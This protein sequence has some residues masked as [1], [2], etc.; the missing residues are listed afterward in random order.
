MTR[1][2]VC[3][4]V[5][6][7]CTA[8][9]GVGVGMTAAHP[10]EPA[11]PEPTDQ[12]S[13]TVQPILSSTE[14]VGCV[15]GICHDDDLEFDE[16]TNLSEAELDALA[17]RTMARVEYLRDEPFTEEVP[18]EIQSRE[19][20]RQSDVAAPSRSDEDFER[21]NDQVWRG[22]FVVGDEQSSGEAIDG[23]VGEAVNGFY[24]P[25]E[26]QIVLVTPS[27]DIPTVD[28]QTLL[29]EFAHALQD[30][31]HNLTS[32]QF[33]GET[34]DRDLAV[35]GVLEGEA[36]YLEYRYEERC[37]S[38]EWSCFD[39]PGGSGGSSGELN[40][41]ILYTLLQPYSDGPA[42]VHEILETEGW[43]GIDERMETPPETTRE[44]IHRQPTEAREVES[45]PDPT[46]GWEP[47][48]DQGHNGTETVG[49]AS[50]FVMLWYQA[51]EY[52]A[53]TIDP[54]TLHETTHEY[55]QFNYVSEPSDG[56]AG[57]QLVPYQRGDDDGYV[58]TLEWETRDD[59]AEFRRAYDAILDA[60]DSTETDEGVYVLSS[61]PFSGAYAVETDDTRVR[62]VHAPT[63]AGL[64]ELDPSLEPTAFEQ[65]P[66]DDTAPGFSVAAAIAAL[67]VLAIAARRQYQ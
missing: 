54:E 17:A 10:S 29:H 55:E 3:V 33:R 62:I 53:D 63:E 7:L 24:L 58:W 6:L 49:E 40:R 27:P 14:E 2:L 46:E 32:P 26:G 57:D 22:L 38:G 25:G 42:Y 13:T 51:T 21:W 41:G 34:Q 4:L 43:E 1:R 36:V 64:F 60:H 61:G 66:L 44:I 18:V 39:D 9:V 16:P 28:E 67:L 11:T 52:G 31:R 37:A 47:Y 19:E 23:T 56:W 35:D 59:V 15:D 20:F 48:P 5:V 50:I 8:G 65:S 30:Q 12:Q 45:P